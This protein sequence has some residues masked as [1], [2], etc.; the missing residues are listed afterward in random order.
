[1]AGI[2]DGGYTKKI[3]DWNITYEDNSYWDFYFINE[4]IAPFTDWIPATSIKI[5]TY[6][7]QTEKLD[8]LQF[9]VGMTLP[10]L[11][12]SYVDDEGLGITRFFNNWLNDIITPDGMEVAPVSECVKQVVFIKYKRDRATPVVRIMADVVPTSA[13]DLSGKSKADIPER[14]QDF[15]ILNITTEM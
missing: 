4:S 3:L 8:N 12:I 13:I 9:P 15:M 14:T 6:D 7:L 1:M 2:S 5:G 10:K 11:S